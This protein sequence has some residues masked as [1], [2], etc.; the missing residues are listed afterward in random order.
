MFID[1]LYTSQWF[2]A[3]L[4]Q[5]YA[6]LETRTDALPW[7]YEVIAGPI[8]IYRKEK[9]GIETV[10]RAIGLR[11]YEQHLFGESVRC[12]R[13]FRITVPKVF[14][15]K[16]HRCEFWIRADGADRHKFTDL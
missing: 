10:L 11:L 16:G 1:C 15:L 9:Y 7:P 3:I 5:I 6:E 12:I 13:F 8:E 4:L 14:F 2:V